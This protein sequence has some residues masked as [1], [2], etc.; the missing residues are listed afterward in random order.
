MS[1]RKRQLP[2]ANWAPFCRPADNNGYCNGQRSRRKTSSFVLI[3]GFR[4]V[5]RA[6]V[7]G[8]RSEFPHLC[9][10]LRAF[11]PLFRRPPIFGIYPPEKYAT[12]IRAL[13]FRCY[14]FD[15][16]NVQRGTA[17]EM[18]RRPCLC[19]PGNDHN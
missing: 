3:R 10:C 19:A 6:V 16:C 4:W 11:S 18:T 14:S 12:V 8:H 9:T 17:V 15:E 7:R 1:R 5:G 2:I 13:L